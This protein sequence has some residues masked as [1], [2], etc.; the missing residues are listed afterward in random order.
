VPPPNLSDY[1]CGKHRKN[2]YSN[3]FVVD[4]FGRF[5]LWCL[6]GYGSRIDVIQMRASVLATQRASHFRLL[7]LDGV[8]DLFFGD[9]I[10]TV[11]GFGLA[12]HLVIPPSSPVSERDKWL[13]G[14][15][16]FFRT[17]VENAPWPSETVVPRD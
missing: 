10:F 11:V 1:Y 9:G 12:K 4:Y 3:L 6:G 14:E 15:H 7:A 16:R 2:G 8:T 17:N 5:L 13:F